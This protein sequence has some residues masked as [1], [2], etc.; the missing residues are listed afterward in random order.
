MMGRAAE[1]GQN[2]KVFW[3]TAGLGVWQ[4]IYLLRETKN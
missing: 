2:G 1:F 3:Q 4:V